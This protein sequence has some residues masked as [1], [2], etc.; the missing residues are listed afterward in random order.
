MRRG[1]YVFDVEH[2]G[3]EVHALF[4]LREAGLVNVRVD[5]REYDKE[6]IYITYDHDKPLPINFNER[7]AARGVIV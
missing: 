4:I 5:D 3:D 2:E 7:M 6:R 1:F